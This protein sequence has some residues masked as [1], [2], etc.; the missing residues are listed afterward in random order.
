MLLPV[1]QWPAPHD[2]CA[3]FRALPI[4]GSIEERDQYKQHL[5]QG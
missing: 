1:L 3:R 5:K 2:V 4:L